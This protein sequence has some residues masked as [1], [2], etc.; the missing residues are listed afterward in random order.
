MSLAPKVAFGSTLTTEGCHFRLH[1]P[2]SHSLHVALFGSDGQ[3]T[4]THPM[5]KQHNGDWSLFIPALQADTA[6]SFYQID[7]VSQSRQWLLDPHAHNVLQRHKIMRR[8]SENADTETDTPEW[9]ALTTC[10]RFDWQGGTHPATPLDSTVISEIHLKGFTFLHPDIPPELRGTYLGLCH[11]AMISFFKTNN[12]TCLQLLPIATKADE[13]HLKA[14]RLSNYW[15]YN[16]L[17]WS[18]PDRRFAME[19]PVTECKT[20]IRTLHA[21]GIEVILD[22]VY[23]HTAEEGDGGP[24]YHFKALDHLTYLHNRDG[25]LKNFT[26][27]GNTVDLCHPAALDAVLQSLRNWVLNYQ[28]DGFRF[29]LAA[30]LGRKDETFCSYAKF[31]NAIQTDPVLSRVKLI[32][33]PWDIGPNGYQLG[34]FPEAWHECNDTFR[35]TWR[36]YWLQRATNTEIASL[37]FGTQQHFP[38]RNWPAKMSVNYICYHDGFTLQDLVSYG[39]KHNH[40]NGEANQ[41]G[42]PDNRSNNHGIEGPS[43][44]TTIVKKREQQKRNLMASLLFSFGIPHVLGADLRSHSQLGNNNAYCQDNAI[45]WINW[46][47]TMQSNRFS[48]YCQSLLALRQKIMPAFTQALSDWEQPVEIQWI[49]ALGEKL[50]EQAWAENAPFAC[51]IRKPDDESLMYL[52]NSDACPVR[53]PLPDTCWTCLTDTADLHPQLKTLRQAST[54][55]RPHSMIILHRTPN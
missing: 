18:A 27:C 11:P 24:V 2:D 49:N 30:T 20:M 48:L 16:P 32:A 7:P 17:A 25:S 52:F 46:Q 47:N 53:F 12:I 42:H 35:D 40:A 28:V 3:I 45:S 21:H 38:S 36:S 31:F 14:K 13:S 33:E 10:H 44:V 6:Y 55:V 50:S 34:Q 1:G 19:D 51:L 23:N 4:E 26:G 5:V 9:V 15:G 43:D 29:D 37:L 22:V 41:D 54:Y 39:D 8:L